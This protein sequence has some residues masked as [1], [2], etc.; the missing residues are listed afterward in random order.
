MPSRRGWIAGAGLDAH[1]V[2]PL[3]EDAPEWTLPNVIVTPHN[4]STTGASKVRAFEVFRDNLKRFAVGEP[5]L[6]VVDKHR[7][8]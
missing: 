6:A 1:A 7:G 3:P 5:L 8:Y 2:E 4:G